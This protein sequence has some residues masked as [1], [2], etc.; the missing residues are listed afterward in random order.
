VP[1]LRHRGILLRGAS[2]QM[3]GVWP[4]HGTI[5]S[6]GQLDGKFRA[7]VSDRSLKYL[8]FLSTADFMGMSRKALFRR[9]P[10]PQAK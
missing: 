10:Q 3:S 5:K 1:K 9:D 2:G 4:N 6:H 7:S 8:L